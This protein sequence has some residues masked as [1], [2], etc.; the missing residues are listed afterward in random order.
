MLLRLAPAATLAV[1]AGPVVLGLA[2]TLL[3]AF[4]FLPALG[5]ATFSLDGWRMLFAA[6]GFA[7]ALA[8]TFGTGLAT[9]LLALILAAGLCAA[10][11]HRPGMARLRRLIM[12]LLASPPSGV[13]LGFAFL[14]M[15]SGW[16]VRLLS[17]WA[18][19]W[20]VPPAEP[21]TVGDPLGA[22]LVAALLLKEVPYLALM[23]FAASATVPVERLI[24][25]A[26]ALGR[27]QATAWATVVFPQLYRQVRLPVFAVLAFSMSVV[28]V[29]IIVGPGNPPPLAVLATRWFKGYDLALYYPAAAAA[30]LQFL[31]VV[32]AIL[33]WLACERPIAALH[34]RWLARGSRSRAPGAAAEVAGALA[35]LL[36][37]LGLLSL[38]AM[39]VWS[40]A[41]SWRFPAALPDHWQLA[42]WRDEAGGAAALAGTSAGIGLAAVA[43]ALVLTLA[44]LENEQ[45]QGLH[46][47]AAVLWLIYLPLIVPQIAF[48]FGVQVLLIH[49]GLDGTPAAVVWAHLV[50]VLPFVF[51]SLAD[52]YRALDPRYAM[53]AAAMGAGRW[54]VFLVVKLPLLARPILVAA[55]VGFAVSIAQYLPT[56]FAGAG[57]V[58]TLTTEAVTLSSGGDRRILGLVAVLQTALPLAAYGLALAVPFLVFRRFRGMA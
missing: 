13:A 38:L 29:A 45:R 39:L 12:P 1:L 16:L 7:S 23:L 48:L 22:S 8:L 41:G 35:G 36:I 25:A 40:F 5:G 14:A 26:R 17:P 49:A 31:L 10:A 18:T 47:G 28:D 50:F 56:L 4:G 19:G 51:L 27:G 33:L 43:I 15:P 24:V 55:A 53:T 42:L 9:T 21:V 58:A 20:Q 3:P 54:R 6:P 2:F 46:P 57:R 44:C 34:R 37:V 52:A 30:T 32:L 11:A